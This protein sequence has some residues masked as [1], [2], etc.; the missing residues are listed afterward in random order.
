MVIGTD[1]IGSNEFQSIH[2]MNIKLHG[3]ASACQ[4][5]YENVINTVI[6]KNTD[7]SVRMRSELLNARLTSI[8]VQ[9]KILKNPVFKSTILFSRCILL[10][11]IYEL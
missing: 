6:V 9:K 11:D 2:T 8:N 5:L 1:C 10:Y 4:I 3:R 7:H